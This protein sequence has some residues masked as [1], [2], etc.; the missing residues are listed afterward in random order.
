MPELSLPINLPKKLKTN[1]L[2]DHLATV[3]QAVTGICSA[4]DN[5]TMRLNAIEDEVEAAAG[6]ESVR[7]LRFRFEECLQGLREET[8]HRREEMAQ[9]LAQLQQ[10]IEATQ[11]ADSQN[12]NLTSEIDPV[13]GLEGRTAAERAVSAAIVRGNTCYAALFV[14]DRLHLINAQFGYASGDRVLREYGQHLKAFLQ[15]KDRL[16]RWTGPAF[17][18]VMERGD[19]PVAVQTEIQKIAG[20]KLEPVVQIGNRSVVL[21]VVSSS[22]MLA[23]AETTQL[24][25]LTS[26]LD[27]FTGQQARH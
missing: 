2:R 6:I 7:V 21:P 19:E 13:S 11:Q 18:V 4:F 20:F 5:C 25:D 14:L 26:R 9:F 23:L 27:A 3:A 22:L 16:F 24:A 8:R 10:Q 1:K 15:P 17:L 12:S